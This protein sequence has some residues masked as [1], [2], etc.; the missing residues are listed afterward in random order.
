M[1]SLTVPEGTVPEGTVPE[2]TVPEGTVTDK[3]FIMAQH[4][5]KS[6]LVHVAPGTRISTIVTHIP[7]SLGAPESGEESSAWIHMLARVVVG[8]RMTSLGEPGEESSVWIP[9]DSTKKLREYLSLLNTQLTTQS[10]AE[11]A[12][13]DGTITYLY[14]GLPPSR[15]HVPA[16]ESSPAPA[17]E[18]ERASPLSRECLGPSKTPPQSSGW[19]EY[20]ENCPYCGTGPGPTR[21]SSRP[22][23]HRLRY[24]FY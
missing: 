9:L 21:K 1:D 18:H 8:A 16:P 6:K 2:G 15:L 22:R 13:R 7:A 14:I 4:K 5:R 17:Q 12:I 24:G 19:C 3:F 11:A 10:E 20:S 23:A